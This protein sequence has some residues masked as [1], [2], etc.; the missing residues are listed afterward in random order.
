ML[1]FVAKR[2]VAGQNADQALINVASLYEDSILSTLDVLGENVSS[3]GDVAQAISEYRNLFEK[4]SN[5]GFQSSVSIKL[6]QLGLD[7]GQEFCQSKLREILEMAAPK[8]IFVRI[9]MESSE[10]TQRTIDIFLSLRSEFPL[11]GIVLQ[12]YLH[13]SLKDAQLMASL[14]APVRVCKG[15]Y[16]EPSSVALQNMEDIRSQYKKMVELL[17]VSGTQVALATHDD[18]LIE[19]AKSLLKR[20][21]LWAQQLEF[22]MLY[23]LRR[24]KAKELARMGYRMRAYV[25]YGKSWFPYFYR[26]L[27]E[28]KENILFVLK[29][30]V[31]D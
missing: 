14:N 20:E 4:I 5:T 9:D 7:L 19:W 27:R 1:E 11:L 6:T 16:K 15:A 22:Q 29:G 25:P 31:Q 3:E 8:N 17:L 23:G 30:M 18:E 2:F 26:R 24:Q 10:Y 13:R 12:A 21:P 28:R